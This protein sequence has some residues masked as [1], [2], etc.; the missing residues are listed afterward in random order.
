MSMKKNEILSL[1]LEVWGFDIQSLVLVE[2]MSE[3][4][5]E[6]IK[7]QR[8]KYFKRPVD[9]TKMIL[10]MA[11]T[12]LMLDQIK[13]SLNDEERDL[14]QKE[15]GAKLNRAKEWLTSGVKPD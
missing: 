9:F 3:L 14:F 6:I 10:E 12:Q 4:T 2:E 1:A 11:D 7:I 8:N 13:H 5:K 15:Y